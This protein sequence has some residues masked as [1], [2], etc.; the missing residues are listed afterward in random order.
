MSKLFSELMPSFGVL[1]NINRC[2]ILS[3]IANSKSILMRMIELIEL[4][5][6]SDGRSICVSYAFIGK[7]IGLSEHQVKDAIPKMIKANIIIKKKVLS[8]NQLILSDFCL[9]R[10]W[11]AYTDFYKSDVQS[12]EKSPNQSVEKSPN[13]SVEKSPNQSVEFYPPNKDISNKDNQK[14]INK[15]KVK[16]Q[17]ETVQPEQVQSQVNHDANPFIDLPSTN[18]EAIEFAKLLYVNQETK[19][20]NSR[21][22]KASSNFKA[23]EDT[24][25]YYSIHDLNDVWPTESRQIHISRKLKLPY[26]NF[27]AEHKDISIQQFKGTLSDDNRD[28]LVD[29]CT[30]GKHKLQI[31]G[32]DE[33]QLDHL[34]VGIFKQNL[35]EVYYPNQAQFGA[36]RI[37]FLSL[38][39]LFELRYDE[40]QRNKHN[41]YLS[42]I[43]DD[44]GKMDIIIITDFNPPSA[45]SKFKDRMMQQFDDL[46]SSFDGSIIIFSKPNQTQK[47]FTRIEIK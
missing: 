7:L 1:N 22:P 41:T 5:D 4:D 17:I 40:Y 35:F 34:A 46:V 42:T 36:P 2:D 16:T 10:Y 19:K 24:G 13:Q 31:V 20:L 45:S 37:A 30:G 43:K 23:C 28:L 3:S 11:R 8:V 32:N 14:K 44:F 18:W 21:L 29:I 47:T 15:R 39:E 12:R 33:T 6:K 27:K 25:K 38:K 26:V 9:A